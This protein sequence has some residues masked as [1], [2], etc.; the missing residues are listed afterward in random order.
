MKP[1]VVFH[2]QFNAIKAFEY[3]TDAQNYAA[4]TAVIL[5]NISEF[6]F[7]E[8]SAIKIECTKSAGAFYMLIGFN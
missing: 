6:I 2:H 5:K 3:H 1:L 8:L 7:N 4:T